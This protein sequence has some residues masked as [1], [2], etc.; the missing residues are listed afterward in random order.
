[1]QRRAKALG[2][3]PAKEAT[4]PVAAAE[5]LP[6]EPREGSV[7]DSPV[8]GESVTKAR[9]P[10]SRV[11]APKVLATGQGA[12]APVGRSSWDRPGQPSGDR[13]KARPVAARRSVPVPAAHTSWGT[14]SIIQKKK[15]VFGGSIP[16]RFSLEAI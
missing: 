10:P 14:C 16:N 3:T 13:N 1:M 9:S 8:A 12:L 6:M 2:F 7:I 5:T 4:A 11:P 15:S